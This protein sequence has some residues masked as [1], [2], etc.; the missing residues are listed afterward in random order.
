MKIIRKSPITNLINTMD[1]PI[2]E[3]QYRS[4][5]DGEH[6]QRAMPHLTAVE[7]E[8]IISGILNQEEWDSIFCIDNE[9]ED[10]EKEWDAF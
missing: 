7:R 8:F 1:L 9:D 5:E 6:I 4:W 10:E 3:E 2:T